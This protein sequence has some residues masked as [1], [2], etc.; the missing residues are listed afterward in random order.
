[1]SLYR[2]YSCGFETKDKT[3]FLSTSGNGE[4]HWIIF[5]CPQCSM[6]EPPVAE[7]DQDIQAPWPYPEWKLVET[8][9]GLCVQTTTK[10][11]CRV[12]TPINSDHPILQA[13][14]TLLR[15]GLEGLLLDHHRRL[16]ED[17]RT[18]SA[19]FKADCEAIQEQ[20][21]TKEY[22]RAQIDEARERHKLGPHDAR[23]EHNGQALMQ[24]IGPRWA[25]L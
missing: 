6:T 8:N 4:R 23:V 24:A 14:A 25:V 16:A 10:R 17:G 11:G 3:V 19:A 21:E 9:D 13:P 5:I 18:R 1:M 15:R 7:V 20:C 2:C 12:T 22:P